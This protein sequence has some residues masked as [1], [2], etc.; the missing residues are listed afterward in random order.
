MYAATGGAVAAL[1]TTR[2]RM[3]NPSSGRLTP[4]ASLPPAGPLR[5]TG[6]SP[7]K[8]S[9]GTTPGTDLLLRGSPI[10]V[11]VGSYE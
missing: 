7:K 5:A 3:P 10:G 4:S 1:I 8:K 11:T 9:Y 6:Q 2:P